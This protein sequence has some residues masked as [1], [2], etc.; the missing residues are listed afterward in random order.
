M[1][2]L[3]QTPEHRRLQ[4]LS[5]IGLLLLTATLFWSP[6][7]AVASLPFQDDRYLQVA[8]APFMCVFLMYWNRVAIFSQARFSPRAGIPLL[9]VAML[10]FLALRRLFIDE[11]AGL[12]EAVFAVTL[13]WMAGFI[14]CYGPRSFKCALFPLCCLFLMIPIPL[15]LMD[16]M[17]VA[18]QHASAATS[19][20][21]LRLAGIPVFREG[22]TFLLPGLRFQVAPECS[23]IRSC[24]AFAV[25]AILASRVCL[26]SGWRRLA[27]IAATIPI[28]IFKNAVR[29]VVITSLTVYVNRAIIDGPLHHQGGPVFALLDFA[30]FLPLLFAL[31]RS[32]TRRFG[33]EAGLAN[34]STGIA[35]AGHGVS[36]SL[37][38]PAA[39]TNVL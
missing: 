12:P 14:L 27:L 37:R 26:R 16:R 17:A 9:S 31:Q 18:L 33:R 10:L 2:S 20:A 8:V 22:M 24:L 11:S 23:G 1:L 35:L 29:I 13:V 3:E 21:I 28:A 34:A 32:E 4:N 25:A 36:G 7:R 30:F 5:A 38:A 6:L 39:E 19:F 15:A